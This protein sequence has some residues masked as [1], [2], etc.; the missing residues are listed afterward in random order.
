VLGWCGPDEFMS[1]GVG[2]FVSLGV[3]EFTSSSFVVLSLVMRDAGK[4]RGKGKAKSRLVLH[5]TV[6][7]QARPGGRSAGFGEGL[8]RSD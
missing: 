2:E 6:L 3:S 1:S 8:L 5:R 4:G 7:G